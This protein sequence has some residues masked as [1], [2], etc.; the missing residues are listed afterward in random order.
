MTKASDNPFPSILFEESTAP[1]SPSAGEQRLFIDSADSALKLKDSSGTVTSVGGGGGGSFTPTVVGKTT[2][3]GTVAAWASAQNSIYLRKFTF[4]TDVLLLSIGMRAK[5]TS[6]AGTNFA[7]CVYTDNA[8]SPDQ[9]VGAS[10][11]ANEQVGFIGMSTA[12]AFILRRPINLLLTAGDYWLGAGL[13]YQATSYSHYSD[14]SGNGGILTTSFAGYIPQG[15]SDE[16]SWTG[17]SRD[18]D[19]QALVVAL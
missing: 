13:F 15:A 8:G 14:G 11:N 7:A 18:Y 9:L 3:G 17:N 2:T 4:A 19:I 1:S 10:D 12:A 5:M 16:G 6:G